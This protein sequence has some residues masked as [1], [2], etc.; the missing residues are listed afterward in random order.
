M[1]LIRLFANMTS[2]SAVLVAGLVLFSVSPAPLSPA[3]ADA[4][5]ATLSTQDK[6]DISRI[7]GYLNELVTLQAG[8]LQIASNGDVATGK[9]FM[10]RPGKMR[11][12]YDPPAPILMIADGVFLIYIDKDLEQVT[13]IW[14]NST[15]VGVLVRENITLKGEV[16]VTKF[17]R[18]PGVLRATVSDT[19]DPEN[20]SITLV[21]SDQPLALRKWVVTDIQGVNTTVTLTGL[22]TGGELDPELFVFRGLNSQP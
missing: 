6:E 4:I 13:H 5:P 7:E 9:L 17:E 22:Q 10:S 14:Q 12:E 15:V 11:F 3:A 19:E 20:G 18:S 2:R 8:F 21:F 16:T 1:K